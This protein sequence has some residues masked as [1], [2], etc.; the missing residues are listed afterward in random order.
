MPGR[1]DS[2]IASPEGEC[3]VM[4]CVRP[5]RLVESWVGFW[6]RGA[7]MVVGFLVCGL[8]VS[9][10]VSLFVCLSIFGFG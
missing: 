5:G 7:D 8:S 6:G 9:L 4:W 10:S 1:D 2:M 3:P